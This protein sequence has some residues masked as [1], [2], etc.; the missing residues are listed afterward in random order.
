M[1]EFFIP[2]YRELSP[3]YESASSRIFRARREADSL[4]VI[5][6]WL[7]EDCP[8]AQERVRYLQEWKIARVLQGRPGVIRALGLEKLQRT[9]FLV[10]EDLDAVS[11]SQWMASGE[12]SLR[13]RLEVA[14]HMTRCLEA[15]HRASVI[16]KDVNPSNFVYNPGQDAMRIIDFGISTQ[17]QRERIELCSLEVLEGSLPYLSPE[18]TGRTNRAV[19][20]RADFYSL[21]VTLYQ[22]FTGRL[23]FESEDPVELLHGHI[24]RQPLPPHLVDPQIPKAL[25]GIVRKLLAKM[26]EERYQSAWGLL[27]DLRECLGQLQQS[28]TIEAFPLGRHDPSERLLV[29]EILYGREQETAT[30]AES[31]ERVTRTATR[32]VLMAGG[33]KSGDDESQLRVIAEALRAGAAGVCVG[34]NVWQRKDVKD[35]LAKVCAMVHGDANEGSGRK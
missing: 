1:T 35:M 8:S 13:Q 21:G 23:P 32:P 30:L 26:P 33:P 7:R 20:Y 5:L 34:R 31:F 16:H 19:D 4:P 9:F 25:S 22:L 6:K 15:V 17:L 3:I 10:L 28:G 2:G 27:T 18:Q 11:V 12:P 29:P 24:L 14:V